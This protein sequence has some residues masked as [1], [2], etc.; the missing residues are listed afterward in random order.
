MA[1]PE[2]IVAKSGDAATVKSLEGVSEVSNSAAGHGDPVPDPWSSEARFRRLFEASRDAQVLCDAR[3]IIEIANARTEQLFGYAPGELYGRA[4]DVLLPERLRGAYSRLLDVLVT[5]ASTPPVGGGRELLAIRKDGTE[6][7]VEVTISPIDLGGET[8]VLTA[9]RDISARKLAEAA[10]VESEARLRFLLASLPDALVAVYDHDLCC[11]LLDGPVLTQAGLDPSA[12]VGRPIAETLPAE[13]VAQLEPLIVR[14]LDGEVSET[15]YISTLSGRTYEIQVAPSRAADGTITGAFAVGRDVTARRAEE[16]DARLLATIVESGEDA[17]IAVDIAGTITHWNAGSSR[18]YGYAAVEA[19]GRSFTMLIPPDRQAAESELAR[20]VRAGHSVDAFDTRRVRRDGTVIDVSIKLSPIRTADG[21]IIGVSAF[22]RDVSERMQRER[23]QQALQAIAQLVA[24][25]AGPDV[26]FERVTRELLELFRCRAAALSRFDRAA[27]VVE[28]VRVLT[29]AGERAAGTRVPLDGRNASAEVYRTGELV[30]IDP[31]ADGMLD[32]ERALWDPLAFEQGV[33]APIRAGG[34][35][36]GTVSVLFAGQPLPADV[37][38]RLA[39][40]ADLASLIISNAHA[41]EKLSRR[42]ATDP[43]T[44]LANLRTFHGRL[45]DEISRA[46]RYGRQL[47]LVLLDIDYFKEVN[48]TL[49]HPAGDR[50]LV[51][52]ARRLLLHAREGELIARIGGEE[53]AWLMPET[54]GPA[55][56]QA[57]ERLRLVIESERFKEVGRLTVSVGVA[58]GDG[59][60]NAE[61]FVRLADRALYRAKDAGRN[62]T[63]LDTGEADA[64]PTG[65]PNAPSSEAATAQRHHLGAAGRRTGGT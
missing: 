44:G 63:F 30:R 27:G 64:L 53:F 55:A 39:R 4:V 2:S 54:G 18:L 22:G 10:L 1:A 40:F 45:R 46:A 50:A 11:V 57:A 15:D 21:V 24:E 41:W 37:E 5:A 56:Y 26:V 38:G 61:T 60:V 17:I 51:E 48:D 19:V 34:E 47:S 13:Q 62:F 23:E 33:V 20:R 58:S 65:R 35:L 42:A 36:W 6:F 8:L 59:G 25:N 9:V 32:C 12:F 14:A 3:G 52:V 28:T 7:P 31:G 29:E 43:L 49:G 16:L